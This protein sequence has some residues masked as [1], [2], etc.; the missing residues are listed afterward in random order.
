MYNPP[1]SSGATATETHS[2]PDEFDDDGSAKSERD[3]PR[4]D[5]LDDIAAILS[6]TEWEASTLEEVADVLRRAGYTIDEFDQGG[7]NR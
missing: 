7:E 5:A 4:L 6:G 3:E 2:E 1:T